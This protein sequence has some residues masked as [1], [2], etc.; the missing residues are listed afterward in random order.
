[1]ISSGFGIL[2]EDEVEIVTHE[3]IL[4]LRL[5]SS[6]NPLQCQPK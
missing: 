6:E 5:L 4:R 3:T 1:M 2:Q